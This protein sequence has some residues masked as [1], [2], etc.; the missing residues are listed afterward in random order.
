MA[1]SSE[2]IDTSAAQSRA[3]LRAARWANRPAAWA[4]KMPP[5]R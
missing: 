1:P 5:G 4:S 3:V 2:T